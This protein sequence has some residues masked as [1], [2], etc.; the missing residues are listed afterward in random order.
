M[1][2]DLEQQRDI[3]KAFREI[4]DLRGDVKELR[5]AIVGIDGHNGLRGELRDFLKRF[6]V[7]QQ[8]SEERT[9]AVEARVEE[10]IAWGKHL[11]E[12]DRHEPGGCLGIEAL[13]QYRK[14]LDAKDRRKEDLSIELRKSRQ[15]MLAAIIVAMLTSAASIIVALISAGVARV[16]Q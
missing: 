6:D 11:W 13:N 15:A 4:S 3:G 8:Q 2:A 1:S 10:G 7:W 5:T 14:E 12:V 9:S 16:A